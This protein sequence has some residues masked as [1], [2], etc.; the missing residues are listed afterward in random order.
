M[1]AT[2]DGPDDGAVVWHRVTPEQRAADAGIRAARGRFVVLLDPRAADAL[3]QP[4]LLEQITRT[5]W[6]PDQEARFVLTT[7]V[8]RGG[9]LTCVTPDDLS[10]ATPVGVAWRRDPEIPAAIEAL[11]EAYE[12][13]GLTP[14]RLSAGRP[15]IEQIAEQWAQEGVVRWRTVA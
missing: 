4:A 5:V 9:P 1:I 14:V 2:F 6:M 7:P 8:G 3:A 15:V 12:Q 13:A 10:R 11:N